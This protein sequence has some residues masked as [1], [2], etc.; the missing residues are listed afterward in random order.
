MV[1]MLD[2][3]SS[4]YPAA[5]WGK[6]FIPHIPWKTCETR[7]SRMPQP[8]NFTIEVAM[9]VPQDR[10][11]EEQLETVLLNV[12]PPAPETRV[13]ASFQLVLDFAP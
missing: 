12:P 4:R 1:K 13:S 9:L 2:A 5:E 3:A 7:D 6:R 11:N 10:R 8:L